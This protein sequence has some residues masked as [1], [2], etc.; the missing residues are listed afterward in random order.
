[1]QLFLKNSAPSTCVIGLM[2]R[3]IDQ[4]AL[5]INT[6][7]PF[8]YLFPPSIPIFSEAPVGLTLVLTLCE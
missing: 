7:M 6:T 4:I 1:M 8:T 2:N 3:D 5:P